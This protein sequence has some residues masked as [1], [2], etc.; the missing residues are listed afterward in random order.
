MNQLPYRTMS[1][2][3]LW[4]LSD[5][6]NKAFKQLFEVEFDKLYAYGTKIHTNRSEVKDAI[7]D[8]FT[9]LWSKR[10]ERKHI[11]EIHFYLLKS[12]RYKLYRLAASRKI[13]DIDRYK[14]DIP[15][16]PVDKSDAY[17]K[18][19][20]ILDEMPAKQREVLHLKFYQGLSNQEIATVLKIKYQSVSNTLHRAYKSFKKKSEQKNYYK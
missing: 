7:Q 18:L 10:K 1:L 5:T 14:G 8:V 15:V 13:I 12:L 3:E 4:S 2:G 11:K 19:N 6:D 20:Y 16:L 9:D 17:Q